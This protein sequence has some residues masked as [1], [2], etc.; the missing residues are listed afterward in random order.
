[1]SNRGNY[2]TRQQEAVAELFA[3]RAE[4]C[5]TAEEAYTALLEQGMDVGQT[6]VYRAI[7]RLCAAYV[8]R[9]YTPHDSGEAARF[10][11]IHANCGALEHLHCD[12]VEAF[13]AHL[14]RHHG[15][16]LDEGQTILYGCCEAC[17]AAHKNEEQK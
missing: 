11:T 8:L 5:L 2:Q 1:M 15:F 6:T 13:A 12:E 10:S 7:A 17:R 9:R 16:T 14:T 4:D 3:K